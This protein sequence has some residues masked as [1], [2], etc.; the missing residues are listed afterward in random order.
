M[1]EENDFAY[2]DTAWRRYVEYRLDETKAAI[3]V[4]HIDN[5]KAWGEANTK[6]DQVL[7]KGY[8]VESQL[9]KAI[10]AHS[11][12][13]TIARIKTNASTI[14][15]VKDNGKLLGIIV[16]LVGIVSLLVQGLFT[17]LHG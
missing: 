3:Q 14:S 10:E 11:Q 2:K 12:A 1:G 4:V 8:I 9:D 6:L 7:N 13:C 16:S 17:I 15:L 5:A